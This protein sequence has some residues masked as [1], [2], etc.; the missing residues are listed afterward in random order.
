MAHVLD[1]PRRPVGVRVDADNPPMKVTLGFGGLPPVPDLTV[2]TIAKRPRVWS[3]GLGFGPSGYRD[4]ALEAVTSALDIWN[5]YRAKDNR[6][7]IAD[8][9]QRWSEVADNDDADE[10]QHKVVDVDGVP[11]P[12]WF[13]TDGRD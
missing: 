2:T 10:W 5:S 4:A 13:A 12:A 1:P 6:P 11:I 8:E 9:V 3:G 7:P